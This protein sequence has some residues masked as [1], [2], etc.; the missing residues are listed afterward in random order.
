LILC[1]RIPEAAVAASGELLPTSSLLWPKIE[2]SLRRR[3]DVEGR[4][5]LR[6][7]IV[8]IVFSSQGRFAVYR[9]GESGGEE[10]L[11]ALYSVGIGGH[12]NKDD[13][14]G[15]PLSPAGLETAL[16][17]AVKREVEE[18]LGIAMAAADLVEGLKFTGWL[19]SSRVPVD[20]DHIGAVYVLDR[21]SLFI[22]GGEQVEDAIEGLT[23]LPLAD[24]SAL[25]LEAWSRIVVDH[26]MSAGT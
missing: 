16:V 7:V 3:G 18:E 26:L 24:V 13:L 15:N 11:H 12:V 19:L 8:Y 23:M 22:S 10:R 25:K 5:V 1:L 2:M 14:A 6:Q 20:L 17:N 21:N 4:Q 9:R